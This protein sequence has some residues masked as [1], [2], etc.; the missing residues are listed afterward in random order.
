[1]AGSEKPYPILIKTFKK[2]FHVIATGLLVSI[3]FFSSPSQ[4][5]NLPVYTGSFQAKQ[6]LI[7]YR[8]QN[9]IDVKLLS[10]GIKNGNRV[11][12]VDLTH[13]TELLDGTLIDPKDI[14]GTI[15]IGPYPFEAS[16]AAFAYKRFRQGATLTGGRSILDV[17][18]LFEPK[19]NSEGWTQYGKIV[20]RFD[21]FLQTPKQDRYLGLYDIFTAFQKRENGY[22]KLPWIQEGPFVNRI[23]S[24]TP[25]QVI[26]T[27]STDAAI[28]ATIVL[29]DGRKFTGPASLTHEL[30]ISDL[31]PATSYSYQVKVG[32]LLTRPYKFRTA[33]LPGAGNV[34]F[35]Y[36][37]NSRSGVGGELESYMGVNHST[38]E[39]LAALVYAKGAQ[40]YL[41]GGDLI[42]GYTTNPI[43]FSGQLYGWKQAISGYWHERP[44]YPG[45]GNH[46]ALLTA[47]RTPQQTVRL[48]RWPYDTQ[49]AEAC[50]ADAFAN[51]TNG[52]IPSDS[53]R[54]PYEKNVFTVHY[55]L[56]KAIA[57]NNN[58][59]YSNSTQTY[60]GSPEG[61][62]LDDQM[63][64][65]E[66]QLVHAEQD[67]TIRY[68][69]LYAQEPVFPCGGHGGDAMW[70]NGD[71]TIRANTYT[72]GS[73]APE[74]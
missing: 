59:W 57:F 34:T 60:G 35:A 42:N 22:I 28:E 47:Y 40:F 30:I 6:E 37:G 25:D 71:K 46:D 68:V 64:W 31:S 39:K 63:R 13:I 17:G 23:D 4:A 33:P 54:P 45:M 8:V 15:A 41:F 11:M 26:I 62:I 51:P 58:Y 16:E 73:L 74:P 56:V 44:V 53:R 21:L 27:F 67:S 2:R 24:R 18:V 1:M 52:P 29:G 69:L 36:C 65:I 3:P 12:P 66:E 70:Y 61:Y 5:Q 19:Y 72:R 10:A 49:S 43:D 9:L 48:D 14:Y 20:V 55:G 32:E 38:I 7:G 50:F